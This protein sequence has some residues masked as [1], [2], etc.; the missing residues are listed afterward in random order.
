VAKGPLIYDDAWAS[1]CKAPIVCFTYV[2]R[3][4][5]VIRPLVKSARRRFRGSLQ[6]EHIPQANLV[7]FHRPKFRPPRIFEGIDDL[8]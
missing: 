6:A 8:A 5:W 7:L 1:G 2:F 4:N 3:R